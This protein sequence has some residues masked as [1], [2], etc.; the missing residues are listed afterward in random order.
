MNDKYNKNL[1]ITCIIST[2]VIGIVTWIISTKYLG[3][4]HV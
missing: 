3:W 2:T 1:I 4:F